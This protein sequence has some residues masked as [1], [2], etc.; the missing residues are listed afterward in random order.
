M[1]ET[2]YVREGQVHAKLEEAYAYKEPYTTIFAGLE[3]IVHPNVYNPEVFPSS[4]LMV[5]RWLRLIRAVKPNSLLEIG[6]GAGYLSILAALNGANTVTA[7]DITSQA[8][9]NM[10]ANIDRYN[11]GDRIRTLY[12]S[13][14]EPLHKNDRFD[15]I[16]WNTPFNHINKPLNELN[17]LERTLFDP[18]YILTEI[19]I[20]EAHKHLTKNGRLFLETS[21]KLGNFARLTELASKYGWLLK[22]FDDPECA[23][24]KSYG[25]YDDIDFGTYELIKVE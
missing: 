9:A 16:F 14:F 15:I 4:H 12:G 6:A 17:E 7:T 22:L 3:F 5:N 11:L 19:Y 20:R 24:E 23:K 10:Q 18:G 25:I 2:I 1:E 13:I 21:K 8:I